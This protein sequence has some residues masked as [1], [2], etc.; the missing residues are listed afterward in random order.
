MRT[1][2]SGLVVLLVVG[3]ATSQPFGPVGEQFRHRVPFEIGRTEVVAGNGITIEEVWGT[4]PVIEVGGSYVVTGTYKLAADS[5]E[6]IF[7][8]TAKN[9][10]NTG[11]DMDTQSVSVPR[12]EGRF[13]LLHDMP[14]PGYFHLVLRADGREVVDV[15]FGH[16]A[17]LLK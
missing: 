6:L 16:G 5:G 10:D 1:G 2:L 3:C 17:T 15:Y 8:Q 11:P 7:W 13:A 9:W 4:R 14:G 12:G